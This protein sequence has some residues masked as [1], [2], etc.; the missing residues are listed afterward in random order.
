MIYYVNVAQVAEINISYL[1]RLTSLYSFNFTGGQFFLQGDDFVFENP[2]L[3]GLLFAI[4]T[5]RLVRLSPDCLQVR[6]CS[7]RED[8]LLA[9][10]DRHSL[11]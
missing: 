8:C 6:T 3:I 5:V 7:L 11:S 1:K 2:V 4:F 10:F 9:E